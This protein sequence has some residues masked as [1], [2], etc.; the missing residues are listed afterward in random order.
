M[1][2]DLQ[3]SNMDSWRGSGGGGK[4][5]LTFKQIILMH[6]QRCVVNGSLEM[7]GGYF[8]EKQL[9]HVLEKTYIPDSRDVFCNSVKVLKVL[10]RGYFDETIIKKYKEVN[11]EFNKRSKE[12][13]EEYDKGNKKESR[14]NYDVFRVK[15]YMEL[16][17]E[18]VLLSKRENFFEEETSSE[19]M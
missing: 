2:E 8:Q 14:D 19:N 10:L 4:F 16:F 3:F 5:G 6:I 11:E 18:L 13:Q 17:E 1:S 15:W 7:R 12:F 9:G